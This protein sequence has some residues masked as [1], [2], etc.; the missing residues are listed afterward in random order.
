MV[1]KLPH[2]ARTM[3]AMSLHPPISAGRTLRSSSVAL[4]LGVMGCFDL[5]GV[6]TPA[7]PGG[8]ASLGDGSLAVDDRTDEVY[9]VR[10]GILYVVEPE[11]GEA[12]AL[13]VAASAEVARGV[14]VVF[15]SAGVLVAY[16]VDSHEGPAVASST[17]LQP[18]A[19]GAAKRVSIPAGQPS[20]APSRRFV[21]LTGQLETLIVDSASLASYSIQ[22][23]FT[24][25]QWLPEGERF[26]ALSCG[27]NGV[28]I[29]SWRAK[30]LDNGK[31]SAE[32]ETQTDL[33]EQ[34]CAPNLWLATAPS[35]NVALFPVVAPKPVRDEEPRLLA[36]EI[37]I[38]LA[39]RSLPGMKGPVT[40]SKDG[41][42]VV[43]GRDGQLQLFDM[44]KLERKPGEPIS[45]QPEIGFFRHPEHDLLLMGNVSGQAQRLRVL[46]LTSGE[47][48]RLG[49]P[50]VALSEFVSA[51]GPGE[52]WLVDHEA[53]FRVD[54]EKPS[55]EL[56]VTE[57]APRHIN[58][59]P[60]RRRL[61]LDDA[62]SRSL[63]FFD[64][65]TRA[66]MT[67]APVGRARASTN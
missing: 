65:V 6:R 40:F 57:F 29:E 22:P 9:L 2:R 54:L 66:V 3:P 1:F 7:S 21:A 50:G 38:R 62:N 33:E 67:S 24:A 11:K 60:T 44:K 14:R 39:P 51:T 12:K 32:R 34:R 42:T 37:G 31:V 15:T 56:V 18:L 59:L 8:V 5:G 16:T 61:V 19:A 10:E 43:G 25:L 47:T 55:L 36:V 4:C 45:F 28:R 58:W 35:S 13:D 27:A 46:D 63:S 64:P 23:P 52:L 48:T 17:W 53:L 49:P 30:A 41:G 26:V 20:V